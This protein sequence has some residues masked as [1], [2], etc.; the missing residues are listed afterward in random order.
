MTAKSS[1]H[2]G[3]ARGV[4]REEAGLHLKTL[5]ETA[6]LT[7]QQVME[8]LGWRFKQR[9]SQ[10]ERGVYRLAPEEWAP[11]ADLLNVELTSFSRDLLRL[12]DPL[13]HAALFHASLVTPA[14]TQD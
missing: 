10:L 2:A 7:Q 4:A 6:G 1:G 5:R 3:V 13:I 11:L 8:G 12:Y 14:K 9:V